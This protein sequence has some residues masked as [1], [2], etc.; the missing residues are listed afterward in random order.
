MMGNIAA[1][2]ILF[3]A[4]VSMIWEDMRLDTWIL[5]WYLLS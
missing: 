5:F 3:L 1:T 2:L 4:I